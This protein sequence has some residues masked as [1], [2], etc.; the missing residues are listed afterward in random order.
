AKDLNIAVVALSQLSR[1]TEHRQDKRPMLSDLRDSGNIEQ[2]A[3]LV[4]MLY[5]SNYYERDP[6]DIPPESEP[7][8]IL[9]NKNRDGATGTITLKARLAYQQITNYD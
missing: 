6:N 1:A 7:L 8:E 3:D 2:D 9:I 5:R 4:L